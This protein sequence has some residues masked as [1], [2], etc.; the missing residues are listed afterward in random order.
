MLASFT[1]AIFLGALLLFLVQPMVGR[2]LLP[3]YGG[4]PAVWNTAMVFYQAALLA[5]YGY[6]HWSTRR[7][8]KKH[9]L[10][11]HFVI[12][13]LPLLALP[14][15]IAHAWHPP[16]AGNPI[17]TLLA[18]LAVT[19]GLPFF[20]VSATSPLLQ[21]WFSQTNHP[22]AAD[23]YFLYAASNAGSLLALLIYPTLIE[24]H[25]ALHQQSTVWT[26][27]YVLL[28]ILIAVCGFR[29]VQSTSSLPTPAVPLPAVP[30]PSRKGSSKSKSRAQAAARAA[31]SVTWPRRWRWV[32]LAFVPNSLM[33][34]VTTYVTT[35]IA[36]IP[37]FWVLSLGLYLLTFVL[38][39]ARRQWI[40]PVVWI[41]AL[42][43]VV[44][45]LIVMLAAN[46]ATVTIPAI[47]WII[48]LNFA[49]LFV[50]AMVCHNTL[51]RD[52]PEVSHLTEFYLWISVGG[53]LG[54]S[55]NALLA[56]LIF[57]D[58]YEYPITLFLACLLLPARPA[59][60]QRSH[61][62]L[63]LDVVL[64]VLFGLVVYAIVTHV[65]DDTPVVAFVLHYVLPVGLCLLFLRRP[66][67]FALGAAAL[68]LALIPSFDPA[69]HTTSTTR[70]FYGILRT[71][72][73][74]G[75]EDVH[76]LTNG[77][78]WHGIQYFE[79]RFQRTPFGYYTHAGPLGQ[80]MAAMPFSLLDR[81][82]V[83]G[84]GAG[85][86]AAYAKIGQHWTFY[87]INPADETIAR[88]PR[89]FTYLQDSLADVDVVLGDGRL[90]LQSVPD[91]PFG[92]IILDAY[93]SD[94]VPI[95]LLTREALAL[96][97]R[98][99]RPDGV[100]LFH[101]SNNHLNLEPVLANL[102]TDAGLNALVEHDPSTQ[103]IFDHTG[104]LDSDWLVM[105]RNAP[106]LNRLAANSR[107]QVPAT[108]PGLRL[109]TDDYASVF[110]I[111]RWN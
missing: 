37:L 32:L 72:Y 41:R 13:C 96:Y 102:A 48:L 11:L 70:N 10:A 14:I 43:F 22:A 50:V 28:V 17:P 84:L 80:A 56:P 79:P 25:L 26:F 38:A 47:G 55:F 108:Q 75:Q 90:S 19:V 99:L 105:S 92:L 40:P 12:L 57:P 34:S 67:R 94:S 51:A 83:V 69:F 85:T 77:T 31:P 45:P 2:M 104:R 81:V 100:L 27:G 89:Y 44:L 15:G 8:V 24:P 95:H 93:N 16:A 91:G 111:I 60:V 88:D 59:P 87:E 62:Q 78:T 76:F 65:Q 39:F 23:P 18:Q 53:V 68:L 61:L 63:L 4:A 52:R 107:W 36:P 110:P 35:Q 20:V 5:G 9:Q 73:S 3:L 82:A 6:A 98:N 49:G 58:V 7:L 74:T 101:I 30:P 64:P 33:L 29:A 21:R 86:I 42:P 66:L 109:W 1:A 106:F 103:E 54:G 71:Q 97:L 46:L